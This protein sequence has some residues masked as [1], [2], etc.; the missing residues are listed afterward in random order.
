[1]GDEEE[2]PGACR[3]G[4]WVGHCHAGVPLVSAGPL[5]PGVQ[6]HARGK[7]AGFLSSAGGVAFPSRIL[8]LTSISRISLGPSR[9]SLSCWKL[10]FSRSH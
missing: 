1:M 2:K 5:F 7:A 10:S 6:M 4:R 9:K 8:V 3:G